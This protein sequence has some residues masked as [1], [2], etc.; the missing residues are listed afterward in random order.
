M[1]NNQLATVTATRSTPVTL[2]SGCLEQAYIQL[3]VP[4]NFSNVKHITFRT[5][6]HDQGFSNEA[7]RYGGTYEECFSFFDA[8]AVTPEGHYRARWRF[9]SHRHARSEPVAHVS[10]W[11]DQRSEPD[12]ALAICTIQAHD[13]IRIIPKAH[14]VAWRNYVLHAEIEIVGEDKEADLLTASSLGISSVAFTQ[15]L[16]R[17]LEES[18]KQIRILKLLPGPPGS[19]VFCELNLTHL[20]SD[21]HAGYEALSYC[22]GNTNNSKA[23]QPSGHQFRVTTNLYAALKR[24]RHQHDKIRTLWVDAICINQ[25]D[26]IERAWQVQMIDYVYAK[27]R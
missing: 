11:P 24:L 25:Q 1:A 9:Q 4:C 10:T 18:R 6:S 16:Y 5:T 17:P 12:I 21:D 7:S 8:A 13:T 23:I 2:Y 15:A 20:C 22:W 14:F 3:T 19:L 27:A 26:L